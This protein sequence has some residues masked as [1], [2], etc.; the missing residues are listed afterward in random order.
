MKVLTPEERQIVTALSHPTY[1][2][3]YL[4]EWINRDDNV[5]INAPAAL[6][7]MGASGFYQAVKSM[8]NKKAPIEAA[9]SV[10]GARENIQVQDST[11]LAS[12]QMSADEIILELVQM[13]K[14]AKELNEIAGALGLRITGS[15]QACLIKKEEAI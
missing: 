4:E 8:A 7:A 13:A 11:D 6:I 1:T 5:F 3:E 14:R 15:F 2:A 10:L 12:C 9:T